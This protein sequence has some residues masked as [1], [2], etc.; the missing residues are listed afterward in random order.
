M[1][2]G[3]E[4]R[5]REPRRVVEEPT[6]FRDAFA[7]ARLESLGTGAVT[8]AKAVRHAKRDRK[9][10]AEPAAS[11]RPR[12]YEVRIEKRSGKRSTDAAEWNRLGGDGWELV[13]VQGKHAFFRRRRR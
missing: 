1:Q 13:A 5:K 4:A 2:H 7:R 12:I 6:A 10:V 9:Q 11:P 8:E 3:A